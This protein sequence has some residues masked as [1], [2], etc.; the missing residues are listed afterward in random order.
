MN[1]TSQVRREGQIAGL[2]FDWLGPFLQLAK[3]SQC[4]ILELDHAPATLSFRIFEAPSSFPPFEGFRNA[5]G[6]ALEIEIRPCERQVLARPHAGCECERKEGFV[7]M[8]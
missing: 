5:H 4:P 3:K 7:P 6:A 1:R 2:A 8:S